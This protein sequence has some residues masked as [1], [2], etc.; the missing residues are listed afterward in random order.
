MMKNKDLS[1][2]SISKLQALL[3]V[4]SPEDFAADLYG[5]TRISTAS[6]QR[7]GDKNTITPGLRLGWLRKTGMPLDKLIHEAQGNGIAERLD[8]TEF[9]N[10]VVA[11]ITYKPTAKQVKEYLIR[12]LEYQ[13]GSSAAKPADTKFNGKVEP[14]EIRCFIR[15][16]RKDLPDG[17]LYEESEKYLKSPKSYF[18]K[19]FDI[20][21]CSEDLFSLPQAETIK[22]V[23]AIRDRVK[24]KSKVPMKKKT[25]AKN[26]AKTTAVKKKTVQ[27]SKKRAE[28]TPAQK[29]QHK[30]IAAVNHLAV[31]KIY[32]AGRDNRPVPT[33]KGVS[34]AA[35]REVFK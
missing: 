34:K 24:P 28:P 30:K 14:K 25:G 8:E 6:F 10:R 5:K 16:A 7:W 19:L 26:T 32:D 22:V 17:V 23:S 33:W 11:F 21:N 4:N 20:P 13:K 27:V 29:R 18:G 12:K 15:K 31:R 35:A 2:L 3:E 9:I 1:S